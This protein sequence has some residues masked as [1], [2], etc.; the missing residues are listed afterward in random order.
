MRRNQVLLSDFFFKQAKVSYY[1][2]TIF[3]LKRSWNFM[4]FY[5]FLFYFQ[6]EKLENKQQDTWVP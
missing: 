5:V 3:T 2:I 4:H 1:L 6:L